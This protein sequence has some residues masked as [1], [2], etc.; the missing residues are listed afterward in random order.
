MK[1]AQP[2][3]TKKE[4]AAIKC[5]LKGRNRLLFIFG[6]NSGLR[7]S[8]ILTLRIKDVIDDSGKP[9]NTVTIKEKK[10]HKTKT[11]TL[12]AAITRELKK[13]EA[14]NR[15]EYL[16]KSRK[17][18]NKPISRIQSHRIL[19]NAAVNAGLSIKVSAHSLR[20]TFGYFAYKKGVDLS[21]LMKIFNHSSQETTLQYIG[22]TNDNINAVY[23][24]LNL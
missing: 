20:K 17:G 1:E 15:E 24:S 10:T 2:I 16:F 9:R 21:L 8:D 14:S 6:I 7:I 11:F 5:V 18:E 13:V 23:D 19:Q 22:I 12:N 3:K 4:I